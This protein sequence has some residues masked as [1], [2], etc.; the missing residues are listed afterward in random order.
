ML[1][2]GQL[3]GGPTILLRSLLNGIPVTLSIGMAEM[4]DGEEAGALL[5]RADQ[6]L[7]QAK[8]EGRNRVVTAPDQDPA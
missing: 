8:D 2:S 1:D 5:H 4:R 6:A 3:G 7:Y